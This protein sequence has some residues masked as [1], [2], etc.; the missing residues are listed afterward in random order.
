MPPVHLA[1]HSMSI[2]GNLTF[3]F[4]RPLVIPQVLLDLVIDRRR[5]LSTS[6]LTLHDFI[7]I[8]V[9]SSIHDVGSDSILIEDY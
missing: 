5:E 9:M 8:F 6:D 3:V 1:I 7:E 2:D 4:S